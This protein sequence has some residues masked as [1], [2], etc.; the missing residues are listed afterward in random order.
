MRQFLFVLLFL[1]GLAHAEPVTLTHM[2]QKT[3]VLETE[4]Q[5]LGKNLTEHGMQINYT[6][7]GQCVDAAKEWNNAGTKPII[8]PYSTNWARFESMTGKPCTAN[9]DGARIA[10][11]R[12]ARQWLC[13]GPKPKPF[14]TP[15]LKVAYHPTQPGNDW[16]PDVNKMNNWAWKPVPVSG[17]ADGL[18]ALANGDIDYYLLVRTGVANKV[19]TG[20]LKCQASTDRGDTIPYMND[21]FRTSG[22]VHKTFTVMHVMLTKNLTEDQFQKVKAALDPKTSPEWKKYLDFGGI[23]VD[24]LSNNNQYTLDRFKE[25]S[26]ES[27]QFYKK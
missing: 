20:E 13:S 8:M 9:L 16:I 3:T 6:A 4:N 26:A 1:S 15:G 21:V 2:G 18:I 17:T 22:D 24:K 27:V 19:E 23:T 25:W 5:M 7:T 14:N 10:M 12:Q 11:V